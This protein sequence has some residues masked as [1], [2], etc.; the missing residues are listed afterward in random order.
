MNVRY[1]KRTLTVVRCRSADWSYCSCF[2]DFSRQIFWNQLVITAHL[3]SLYSV[4]RE[5]FQIRPKK[6][7]WNLFF[8][9]GIFFGGIIAAQFLMNQEEITV[10]PKLKTEL[11]T[12]GITG[13]SNLAPY[14]TNG[15]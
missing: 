13:Y 3:C 8:V 7:F 14:T 1:H 9:L 2:A 11:V 6:E 12:Y 5:L 10:N 15:F 4:K